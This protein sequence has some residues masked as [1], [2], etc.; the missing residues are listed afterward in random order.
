[1]TKFIEKAGSQVC[2][3]LYDYAMTWKQPINVTKTVYQIF[4]TQ[5][6]Q[7]ELQIKMNRALLEKIRAF[8]YLGFTWTDKLSLKPTVDICLE[9]IQKSYSKLKWLKRNKNISTQV[10][11]T[12]FF[13]Y[14]F[15]FSP[16]LPATQQELFRRKYRVGLRMIYRCSFT[17]IAEIFKYTKEPTLEYYVCKY[18]RKRFKKVHT[19]DLGYSHFYE[20]IFYWEKFGQLNMDK[21]KKTKVSWSRTLL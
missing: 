6:R 12:C 3:N 14:S 1:M 20:D 17:G 21:R 9:N 11:R 16:L 18:L 10:L 13:T 2:Q 7:P 5:V 15:P 19:T 8:K 4:H